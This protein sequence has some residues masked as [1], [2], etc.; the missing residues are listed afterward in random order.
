MIYPGSVKLIQSFLH[1]MLVQGRSKLHEEEHGKRYKLKSIDNNEIDTFFVD[2]REKN[3]TNGKTLV[4]CSE[5]KEDMARVN[6]P[7]R[8]TVQFNV[9]QCFVFSND[10]KCWLLRN[11]YNDNAIS[12]KLLSIGVESSRIW[13]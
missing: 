12:F 8:N 10:R 13:R 4:I 11:R 9:T 2:N 3:E 6:Y 5:G 1:P 7:N